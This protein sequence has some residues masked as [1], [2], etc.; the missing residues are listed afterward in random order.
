MANELVKAEQA[1]IIV[2]NEISP[3]QASAM[4]LSRTPG[5]AWELAHAIS[6]SELYSGFKNPSAAFIVI[7]RGMEMGLTPT[8]ALGG[9]HV[10]KGKPSMSADLMTAVVLKSGLCDYFELIESSDKIATYETLRKGAR[11]PVKMSFT[12]EEAKKAELLGKDNWKFFAP[13]MLRA[14]CSSAL[15]RA[16]YPD[17]ISGV[18][19]PEELS[20]AKSKNPDEHVIDIAYEQAQELPK[21]QQRESGVASPNAETITPTVADY[22]GKPYAQIIL[23]IQSILLKMDKP[24]REL[25]RDEIQKRNESAGITGVSSKGVPVARNFNKLSLI[26]A[27][28]ILKELTKPVQSPV[29]PEVIEAVNRD[30]SEEKFSDVDNSVLSQPGVTAD[31]EEEG[32]PFAGEPTL[33]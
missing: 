26:D 15:S 27:G 6:Q 20:D 18:Y 3:K 11:N 24:T 2:R 17:V 30:A 33:L 16:V 25:W 32:D 19:T 22:E 28:E 7:I 31:G 12:I 4:L 9:M 5:E 29:E 21:P 13:A 1:D 23:D 10:I 14:R 8:V